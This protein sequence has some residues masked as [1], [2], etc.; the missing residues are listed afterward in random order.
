[1]DNLGYLSYWLSGFFWKESVMSEA[2]D[3]ILNFSFNYLDLNNLVACA[4]SANEKSIN[5]L[6]AKNFEIVHADEDRFISPVDETR[7]ASFIFNLSKKD[8]F[9][10]PHEKG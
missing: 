7:Y 1:M 2:F 6:K 9:K 5:L 8:Y 10:R 4:A 3:E